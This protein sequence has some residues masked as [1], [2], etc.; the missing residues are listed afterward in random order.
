MKAGDLIYDEQY[1]LG[2]VIVAYNLSSR[3]CFYEANMT[4]V[5]GHDN[6]GVS[7]SVVSASR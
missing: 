5:L 1:G 2:I 3:V 7:A 4:G 6:L